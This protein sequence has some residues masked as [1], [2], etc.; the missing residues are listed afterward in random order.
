MRKHTLVPAVITLSLLL[1]SCGGSGEKNVT[2]TNSPTSNN[3]E[4]EMDGIYHARL[5]PINKDVAG[6]YL[7]GSL[8]LLR[9]G[10]DLIA[11]VRL[12]GAPEDTLHMQSIHIG[13]RCPDENDDLNRDGIIDAAEGA[14]VYKEI[15]IPLDDDLSSQRMGLGI[16]PVSD[17]FGSYFWSRSVSYPKLMND[18]REEDINLKDSYIKIGHEK[19]LLSS[20]KVVVIK[21]IPTSYSLPSTVQGYDREDPYMGLPIAC[22]EISKLESVPGEIDRDY[23]GIP[24]PSE[25]GGVEGHGSDDGAIFPQEEVPPLPGGT[26]GNYGDEEEADVP[27]TNSAEF[28]SE[29]VRSELIESVPLGTI[30]LEAQQYYWYL[31]PVMAVN[32]LNR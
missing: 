8:T 6:K 24:L 9:N 23:T 14:A 12:S 31:V 2:Q 26:P 17:I 7:N 21:G 11:D 20:A 28:G 19:T 22:G 5:R 15:L 30:S 27:V 10:E 3:F 16:F 29:E 13:E 25:T 32:S 18:L 1:S 4:I